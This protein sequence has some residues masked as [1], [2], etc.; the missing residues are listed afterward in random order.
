MIENCVVEITRGISGGSIPLDE[1]LAESGMDS[2]EA[3]ELRAALS[4]AFNVDLPATLMY[5]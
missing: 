3:V 4:Q 5:D 2:L 1:P